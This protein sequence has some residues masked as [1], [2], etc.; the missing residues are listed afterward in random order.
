MN[1]ELQHRFVSTVYA[2]TPLVVLFVIAI[3][4]SSVH[5]IRWFAN[6]RQLQQNQPAQVILLS[7]SLLSS[8]SLSLLLLLLS[9]SSSLSSSLLL[10]SLFLVIVIAVIVVVV[11]V[12]SLFFVIVIIAVVVV[13]IVIIVV[14]TVVVVV[15][16]IISFSVL[17]FQGTQCLREGDVCGANGIGICNRVNGNL[18]CTCQQGFKLD[19][20]RCVGELRF[21]YKILNSFNRQANTH[22]LILHLFK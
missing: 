21:E 17:L 7:L 3:K 13:V 1:V 9:S 5:K 20:E 8:S 22:G 19:G 4:A 11:V 10:L 12:I 18:Q 16:V 15:V 6:G 14:V 2:E